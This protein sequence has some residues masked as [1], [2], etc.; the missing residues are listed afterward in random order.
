MHV[1]I[2]TKVKLFGRKFTKGKIEKLFSAK[3][4]SPRVAWLE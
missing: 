2:Y 3:R 4:F 1:C